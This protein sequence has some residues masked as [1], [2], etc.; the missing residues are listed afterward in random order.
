MSG[1]LLRDFQGLFLSLLS[2]FQTE[3]A[4]LHLGGRTGVCSAWGNLTPVNSD[5]QNRNNRNN[6][7]LIQLF[8]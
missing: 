8:R 7:Y 6:N 5:F 2:L 4:R 1:K 3:K